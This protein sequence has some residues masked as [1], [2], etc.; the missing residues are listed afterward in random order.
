MGLVP[1][2]DS[3]VLGGVPFTSAGF[4]DFRTHGSRMRIADLSAPS[5][6]FVACV[7]ASIA[8]VDSCPGRGRVFPAAENAFDSVFAVPTKVGT[9]SAEAPAASTTVAQPTL[10]SGSWELYTGDRL[11]RD[12]RP[13]RVRPYLAWLSGA[14][15]GEAAFGLH[16]HSDAS[17]YSNSSRQCTPCCGLWRR[18]RRGPSTSFPAC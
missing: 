8:P 15:D 2:T 12:H 18:A 5:G 13:D 4:I 7:S 3:A 14:S 1:G 17:T 9:G 11:R 16:L 6:G 10:F